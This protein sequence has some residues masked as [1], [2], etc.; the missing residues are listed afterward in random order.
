MIKLQVFENVSYKSIHH[1]KKIVPGI[2]FNYM[3]GFFS[4][5]V[6]HCIIQISCY[7]STM[8]NKFVIDKQFQMHIT[9]KSSYILKLLKNIYFGGTF[10]GVCIF[11][12]YFQLAML[13]FIFLIFEPLLLSFIN[14]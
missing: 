4:L 5:Y 10:V 2:E 14:F 1:K 8:I 7:N 3:C 13:I 9:L 6:V 11:L 12:Q